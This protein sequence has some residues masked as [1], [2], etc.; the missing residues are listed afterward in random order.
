[1]PVSIERDLDLLERSL[2]SLKVDYERFFAGDLKVPPVAARRK[3][4]EVLRRVGNVDVERAAEAF[5]LQ[6]LQGRFT[7]L[8]ELWDKRVSAKEEG[9]GLFRAPRAAAAPPRP[10]A[11]PPEPSHRPKSVS[12]DGEGSTS[13][14]GSDGATSSRSSTA[15]ARPARRPGRT[16]RS[17][18]T[19]DSRTS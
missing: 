16:S 3:V 5:R 11:P 19:T 8:T 9:R 6:A 2:T 15:T 1:M 10:A 12:S 7:A 4:E 17:C 18:V 13:V 14:K